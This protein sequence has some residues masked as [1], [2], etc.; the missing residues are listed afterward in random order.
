ME[1]AIGW[2]SS[3]ILVLTVAKQV[4][5]QWKSKTSEGV[6]KWLF[7]GQMTASLGFVVYSW[8]VANW[9]FV[10][11]NTLML[12]NAVAGAAIVFHQRRRVAPAE[13][14][15]AAARRASGELP[16]DLLARQ[17]AGEQGSYAPAAPS[18][19]TTTSPSGAAR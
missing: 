19:A 2:S 11:T 13:A 1:D 16:A 15:R 17:R 6:S 7:L 9:V 12:V 10:A 3:L 18:S 14:R 4:H 5:K 8:L